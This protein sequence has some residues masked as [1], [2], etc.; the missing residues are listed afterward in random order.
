MSVA[1]NPFV[2]EDHEHFPNTDTVMSAHSW[3]VM[4]QRKKVPKGAGA[5]LLLVWDS[6]DGQYRARFLWRRVSLKQFRSDVG[7][8]TLFAIHSIKH[9]GGT[10]AYGVD[11]ERAPR[12]EVRCRGHG[13][14]V[15]DEQA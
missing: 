3:A 5:F 4:T 6:R 11:C 9:C 12:L 14:K 8:V 10:T 7:F 13:R 2:I 15:R 1:F